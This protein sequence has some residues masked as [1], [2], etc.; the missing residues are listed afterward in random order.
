[1]LA[2]ILGILGSLHFERIDQI[3]LLFSYLKIAVIWKHL[4]IHITQM[5][6]N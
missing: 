2:R 6:K 3:N 1:M 4:K 5:H